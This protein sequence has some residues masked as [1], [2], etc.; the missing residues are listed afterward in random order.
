MQAHRLVQG[1]KRRRGD[2]GLSHKDE[3]RKTNEAGRKNPPRPNHEKRDGLSL[4]NQTTT[5][6]TTLMKEAGC[7]TSGASVVRASWR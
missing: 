1:E 5:R 6:T 7:Q 4:S 3:E 2:G